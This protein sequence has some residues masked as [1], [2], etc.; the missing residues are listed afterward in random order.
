MS[1]NDQLDV[2][3]PNANVSGDVGDRMDIQNPQAPI[4]NYQQD[5]L[6]QQDQN[7]ENNFDVEIDSNLEGNIDNNLE[8][9]FDNILDE[10]FDLA[11]FDEDSL[12]LVPSLYP[13]N[14]ATTLTPLHKDSSATPA[15]S[16]E[17]ITNEVDRDLQTEVEPIESVEFSHSINV[18]AN[19]LEPIDISIPAPSAF[20]PPPPFIDSFDPIEEE[21]ANDLLRDRQTS[22]ADFIQEAL[23]NDL[24]GNDLLGND[25]LGNDLLGDDLLAGGMNQDYLDNFDLDSLDTQLP[26]DYSFTTPAISTGLNAPT[27]PTLTPPMPPSMPHPAA[28]LPTPPPV[29]HPAN[30]YEEPSLSHTSATPLSP[31]SLPPLPPRRNPASTPMPLPPTQARKPMAKNA[32]VADSFDSF[33]ESSGRSPNPRSAKDIDSVDQGWSDLLD[34]DTVLSGVLRS[35]ISGDTSSSQHSRG[36]NPR[37]T[38]D[39]GASRQSPQHPPQERGRNKSR[40]PS[41]GLPSFDELGLEVHDD[42]TDWSGLLDSGDLSDSITTIS[43]ANSHASSRRVPPRSDMTG[44]TR[45]IPRDRRQPTPNFYE[46]PR[47]RADIPNDPMDFNRFTEDN[48][49]PY[50]PV[51]PAPEAQP[52]KPKL[53]LPSVSLESMWQDYLKYPVIGLV[54]IGGAFLLYSLVNRPIF[55]LG[56]RSGIFKD[57]KGM[58]FTKADF[59]GAKLENVD[60]SEAILMPSSLKPTFRGQIFRMQNWMVRTLEMPTLV[61]QD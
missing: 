38:P 20:A 7:L 25:L 9:N 55:D 19:I 33:H 47:A 52:Q 51:T 8:D 16:A 60:F 53:T 35:P 42:N 34:A 24:L 40:K 44:E 17:P 58:D 31:P 49:D 2:I 57:A 15:F 21:I 26:E 43:N 12:P 13:S 48:Y 39:T 30:L 61:V 32:P 3:A 46:Q 14:I 23:N 28:P 45:E 27:A 36:G 41:T 5:Y 22:E 6:T 37:A 4:D 10:N 56:L 1:E 29:V 18:D 54:A 50:Q 59:T 11:A